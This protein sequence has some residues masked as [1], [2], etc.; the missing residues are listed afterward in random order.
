MSSRDDGVRNLSLVNDRS[1]EVG[2]WWLEKDFGKEIFFWTTKGVGD[3]SA[4]GFSYTSIAT[5]VIY[6]TL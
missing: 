3:E 2:K 5:K 4:G 1:D 6:V